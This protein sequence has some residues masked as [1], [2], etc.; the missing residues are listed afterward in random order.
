MSKIIPFIIV[1]LCTSAIQ[2]QDAATLFITMPDDLMPLLEINRRKDL[3][4]LKNAGRNDGIDNVFGEKV[5]IEKI[6]PDFLHIQLSEKSD[7]QIKRLPTSDTTAIVALITTL[8]APAKESKIAFYDEKWVQ[9][10]TSDY[11]NEPT[12]PDFIQPDNSKDS[13]KADENELFDISL[14]E[15]SL[16]A[17][18]MELKARNSIGEYM[19]DS[20]YAQIRPILIPEPINWVW[21]GK[22]FEKNK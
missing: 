20:I 14:I 8:K 7:I 4:D 17:E 9:L 10:K 15:Y 3:V 16:S 19:P 6:G 2:A 11:L 1:F 18:N 22:R 12:D 21:N 13:R 5:F